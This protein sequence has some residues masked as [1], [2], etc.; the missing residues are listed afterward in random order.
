MS[1]PYRTPF[2][3]GPRVEEPPE[4]DEK[5]KLAWGLLVLGAIRV[6]VALAIHER[7]GIEPTLAAAM[8][9]LGAFMRIRTR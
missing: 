2:E 4:P 3:P 9:A 8:L 6:V 5:I 7:W 1:G